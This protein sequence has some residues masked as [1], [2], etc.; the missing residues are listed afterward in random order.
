VRASTQH[1]LTHLFFIDDVLLFGMICS[2][3]WRKYYEIISDFCG[4]TGMEISLD[5]SCFISPLEVME[6]SILE[7]FPIVHRRLDEG[8]RYLGYHLKPNGYTKSD[9]NWLIG[10][11]ERKIGLWCYRYLSLGGILT[12]IKSVLEG[13]PIY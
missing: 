4:A 3:E 8:I 10:R 5:K 12:L 2:K 11:V 1:I 7:L 13:I 9:W 6:P